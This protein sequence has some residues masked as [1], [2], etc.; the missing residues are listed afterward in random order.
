MKDVRF[1]Y[2]KSHYDQDGNNRPVT[3]AYRFNDEKGVIEFNTAVCG[4]KDHFNRNVGRAV[5]SGRLAANKPSHPNQVIPYA[6]VSGWRESDNTT[7]PRYGLIAG[8]LSD[9][10]DNG[11]WAISG[12]LYDDPDYYDV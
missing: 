11:D 7:C 12:V 6:E 10:F 2:A 5:S 3:V 1:F 4:V 8:V 9:I